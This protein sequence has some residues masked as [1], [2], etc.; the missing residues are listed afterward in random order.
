MILAS[1][2]KDGVATDWMRIPGAETVEEWQIHFHKS[3]GGKLT[4]VPGLDR[5]GAIAFLHEDPEPQIFLVKLENPQLPVPDPRI[6]GDET[7][8]P[9]V[10]DSPP[11]GGGPS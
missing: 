7:E 6:R 11:L 2:L 3:C 10:D 5:H 4:R 9:W 8:M 1:T